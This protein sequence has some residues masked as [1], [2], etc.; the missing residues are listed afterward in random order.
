[1]TR[2]DLA[3]AYLATRKITERLCAPLEIEDHVIQAMDD[4][5]PPKWHLGHTTWFFERFLL[6]TFSP[7]YKP[8]HELYEFLFNSYYESIG[9]RWLRANRGLLSRPTVKEVNHYRSTIDGRMQELIE[10][11][12]EKDWPR[13]DS[14]VTLGIHHEQQ[15]Q[16]L[17]VT[18]I[19]SILSLNPL[20]PVYRAQIRETSERRTSPARFVEFPGGITDLGYSGDAFSFDN[21]RPAHKT[22]VQGF[23]LHDRLVTNA[24]Y[25]EFI[26]AGGYS[27][28]RHWLSDGWSMVQDK[29]WKSPLY[30]EKKDDE[31]FAMTLAGYVK[32]NPDEPVCHVSYYEA[33]A[34]AHWAGPGKRLPTEAEWECAARTCELSPDPKNFADSE[35]YHPSPLNIDPQSRLQQ[36]LGDVWEWTVSAY[37]PYPGFRTE[38]GAV[39]EY[40]GKFMSNQMV[41]R[42]GSCATPANHIRITYRNFFQCDKR[43]QFTGIRL[44]MD[45]HP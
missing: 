40:N 12:S 6:G 39:G 7:G 8:V 42:G 13:F 44:A 5:S 19:K 20:K 11:V 23:Q 28:F 33:D 25:I 22:F 31:W 35:R 34:F 2:K 24:E 17:L 41:L 36:M 18:D 9:E 26:N 38:P 4:V 1:M 30:W 10:N 15:H 14:L 3:R 45:T 32:V 43:W 27:D 29:G 16:E 21:E 37:L